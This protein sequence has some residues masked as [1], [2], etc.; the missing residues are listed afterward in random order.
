MP[1]GA[2]QRRSFDVVVSSSVPRKGFSLLELGV[3]LVLMALLALVASGAFSYVRDRSASRGS[4]PLLVAAQLEVRRAAAV[5]G[6]FPESLQG[7]LLTAAGGVDFL[8][9]P[10]GAAEEV[11]VYRVSTTEVVLTAP[12]GEDCLVLVDRPHGSS[13]WV[14]VLGAG[15][16]C[17]AAD[18]SGTVLALDH[19]GSSDVPQEVSAGE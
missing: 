14:R 18:L 16:S 11:S 8:L 4:A 2:F 7:T 6:T 19:A 13:T 10:A 1:P 12:S 17:S 9:G 5:D 15:P 3:A